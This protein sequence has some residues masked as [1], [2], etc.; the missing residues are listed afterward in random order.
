MRYRMSTMVAAAIALSAA[1]VGHAASQGVDI[2]SG[3]RLT[4]RECIAMQAAKN[5]GA[6]R[7]EMKRA[8][9]WTLDADG[10][11]NPSA[12]IRHRAVE[13]TP[14]VPDNTPPSSLDSPNAGH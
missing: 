2:E 13:S 10:S 1:A 9:Q 5:D 14:Y 8:C 7:T 11:D 12:I 3:A 6:T 4:M